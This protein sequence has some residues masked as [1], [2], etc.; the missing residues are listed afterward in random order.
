MRPNPFGTAIFAVPILCGALLGAC[1]SKPVAVPSNL[2]VGAQN[3]RGLPAPAVAKPDAPPRILAIR[4]STLT[5]R[6]GIWFDG[7]MI[8]STNVASVEVR[9]AAFSINSEHVGPGV[10]RFHT[11]VLE[12]PP[13][14]RRHWYELDIIA[15]NTAG[16]EMI[17]RAPLRVE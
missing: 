15:R 8:C 6:P 16:T 4:F 13:L 3:V 1:S 9:T 5:I 7:T 10:Y 12:L 11:R 17:E 2:T 14:S